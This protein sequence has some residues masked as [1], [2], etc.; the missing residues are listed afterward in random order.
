[1]HTPPAS[2]TRQPIPMT[3]VARRDDSPGPDGGARCRALR[4]VLVHVHRNSVDMSLTID[5]R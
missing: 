4:P 2:H 1:M 5:H 3:N